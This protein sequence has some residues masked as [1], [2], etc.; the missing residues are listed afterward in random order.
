MMKEEGI[1]VA[2]EKWGG[3]KLDYTTPVM[4]SE[5]LTLEQIETGNTEPSK[6]AD[7][8]GNVGEP[9]PE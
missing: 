4:E 7:D 5:K 2:S 6:Q 9:D 8:T 1:N 3:V